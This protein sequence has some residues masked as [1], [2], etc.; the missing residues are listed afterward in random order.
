M[1]KG[2]TPG[3]IE[4]DRTNIGYW[5]G[6]YCWYRDDG[7]IVPNAKTR[8]YTI[9]DRN[10]ASYVGAIKWAKHLHAYAIHIDQAPVQTDML[11]EIAEFADGATKAHKDRLPP[12]K[13]PKRIIKPSP[14]K[15][16]ISRV[17]R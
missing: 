12:K 13:Q 9:L 6:K 4:I 15:T 2:Y 1:L 5:K 3:M 14:F 7:Y 8:K 16:T 10:R 17:P 11:R